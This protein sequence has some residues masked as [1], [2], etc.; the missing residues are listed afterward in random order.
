MTEK[1]GEMMR[2]HSVKYGKVNG[3]KL[4]RIRIVRKILRGL[5]TQKAGF[6]T[7]RAAVK[8]WDGTD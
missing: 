1:S 3:K 6:E 7:R 4:V 5:S 8:E 2:A